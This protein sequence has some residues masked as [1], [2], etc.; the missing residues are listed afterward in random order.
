M[1]TSNYK[2]N[3]I[4]SF[5]PVITMNF[6]TIARCI[7]ASCF[8]MFASIGFSQLYAQGSPFVSVQT[9]DWD[10]GATWGNTSP[11]V[12]GTDYPSTSGDVTISSNHTVSYTGTISVGVNY[13]AAMNLTV[14]ADAVLDVTGDVVELAGSRSV[15]TNNGTIQIVGNLTQQQRDR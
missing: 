3:N 14:S 13:G 9:G 4:M 2:N 1:R 7:L 5:L 15:I 6:K 11:G 12:A 8:F 10:D